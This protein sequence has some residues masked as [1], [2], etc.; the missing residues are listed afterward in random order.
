MREG[1]ETY[2][3]MARIG[4]HSIKTSPLSLILQPSAADMARTGFPQQATWL[5]TTSDTTF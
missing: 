2:G 5:K 3:R 1:H 4:W